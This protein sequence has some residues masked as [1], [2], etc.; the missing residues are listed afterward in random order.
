MRDPNLYK[1][2]SFLDRSNER[3]TSLVNLK[4]AATG[5]QIQ[6]VE[7]ALVGMSACRM[8]EGNLVT[9]DTISATTPGLGQREMKYLIKCHDTVTLDK[10]SISVPGVRAGTTYIGDT[11][12]VDLIND[13]FAAALKTALQ[14]AGSSGLTENTIAVDSIWVTRGKK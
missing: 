8:M 12:E 9:K 11:D 13:T 3:A 6:A 10:F 5:P 4:F 2:W 1:S 7:D 14:A